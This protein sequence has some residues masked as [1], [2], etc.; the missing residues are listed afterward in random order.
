MGELD[1]DILKGMSSAALKIKDEIANDSQATVGIG[2]FRGPLQHP[3]N[4]GR[5][6][7]YPI[8]HV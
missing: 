4:N 7:L 2:K 5:T 1:N 3:N 6:L 8:A